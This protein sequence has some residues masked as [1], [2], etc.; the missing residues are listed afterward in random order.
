MKN[1][2]ENHPTT[3]QR[4]AGFIFDHVKLSGIHLKF[5]GDLSRIIS[6]NDGFGFSTSCFSL[7]LVSGLS[8]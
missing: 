8:G 1:T 4:I 6:P 3:A 2:T 5:T 7:E